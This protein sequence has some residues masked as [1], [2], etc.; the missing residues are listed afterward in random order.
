MIP[1]ADTW[2]PFRSDIDQPERV[3]RLRCLRAVV[4]LS[5]G[6]RGQALADLLLRAEQDDELLPP[7]L[8]ALASLD[9][10]DKRRVWASYAA[11]NRTAA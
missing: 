8:S 9:P 2:G 6:P 3:A 10:L 11:L 1:A 5:T 4:H 7:A